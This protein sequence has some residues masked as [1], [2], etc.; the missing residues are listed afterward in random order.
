M[1]IY[2]Q[3]GNN[4]FATQERYTAQYGLGWM[5]C[6]STFEPVHKGIFNLTQYNLG[7]YAPVCWRDVMINLD[8][9][10]LK[11]L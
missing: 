8:T 1:Y 11:L 6:L 4:Y 3:Y 2:E 10:G 5:S 7:E 9:T